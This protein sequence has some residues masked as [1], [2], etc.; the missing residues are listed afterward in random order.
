MLYFSIQHFL[1]WKFM[2]CVPLFSCIISENT[3]QAPLIMV[4]YIGFITS[5]VFNINSLY[6]ERKSQ[7]FWNQTNILYSKI[8]LKIQLKLQSFSKVERRSFLLTI[9][10][11]FIS[12]VCGFLCYSKVSY[13]WV[14]KTQTLWPLFMDG[15]QLPQG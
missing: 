5:T 10:I 7:N 12:R 11:N 4:V 8:N 14:K 15:V 1:K 6:S 13:C 3:F 9:D 2:S